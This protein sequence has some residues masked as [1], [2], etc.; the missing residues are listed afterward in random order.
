[1]LQLVQAFRY[2]DM[3]N[4]SLLEVLINRTVEDADLAHQF[5]W[6][7]KLEKEN[8]D[9]GELEQWYRHV[10][11]QFFDELHRANP[12]AAQNLRRQMEFRDRLYALSEFIRADKRADSN[13][14][15]ISL[16]RSLIQSGGRFDLS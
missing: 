6:H 3:N 5:H 14:K 12:E 9:N 16:L 7:L 4:S 11:D 10:Y 8:S 2:E 13:E 15:K 1:M